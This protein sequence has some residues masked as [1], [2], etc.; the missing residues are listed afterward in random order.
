MT[1]NM[2][3]RVLQLEERGKN[4]DMVILTL[5]VKMSFSCHN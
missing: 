2:L 1:K 3:E 5:N 4:T